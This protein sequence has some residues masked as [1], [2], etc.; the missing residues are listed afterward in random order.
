M[1]RT[2]RSESKKYFSGSDKVLFTCFVSPAKLSYQKYLF[3]HPPNY[4]SQQLPFILAKWSV[5]NAV[6]VQISVSSQPILPRVPKILVA[7]SSPPMVS[8]SAPVPIWRS[9]AAIN[10]AQKVFKLNQ[11][12]A[13]SGKKDLRC[14][15][16]QP[17]W[18]VNVKGDD[19]FVIPLEDRVNQMPSCKC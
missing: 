18:G 6:I 3:S 16:N 5:L 4:N 12:P 2:I 7:R 8:D 11:T 15:M 19:L 9:H 10:Y 17:I 1:S 13:I 14:L